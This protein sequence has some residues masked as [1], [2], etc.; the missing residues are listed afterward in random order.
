MVVQLDRQG[1]GRGTWKQDPAGLRQLQQRLLTQTSLAELAAFRRDWDPLTWAVE[2][3]QVRLPKSGPLTF[4]QHPFLVQVYRDIHP[5]IVALKGAQMGFSTWALIRFLW[6]VT[7]WPMSVIYTF[8]VQGQITEHTQSRIN[9]VIL[10]SSYL[11][12]RI[13]NVD[14]VM[15]KQFGLRG[16][17]EFPPQL[18]R[19]AAD[20]ARHMGE[21]GVSTVYFSGASRKDVAVAKDADMLIH[22]EEDRSDPDTIE[23]FSSRLSGPSP[24]KWKIRLSTPT[25]PGYGI[26][27]A[28]QATDRRRWML[29]CPHCGHRYVMRFPENIRPQTWAEHELEH[30]G[31]DRGVRCPDCHYVCD[32]CGG[33]VDD[34]RMSGE[35]VAERTTAGLA[36]GYQVGQMA[37]PYVPASE[38]LRARF[39]DYT[40]YEPDFWNVTMG[41]ASTTGEI[42][43]TEELFIGRQTELG[44]QP[45]LADPE[46][47]MVGSSV[48]TF[49]GVDV[50]SYLDYVVDKVER[51]GQVRTVAFGRL[52]SAEGGWEQLVDVIRAHRALTVVIDAFPEEEMTRRLC[53]SLNP[54]VG[55]PRVWRAMY[56]TSPGA[57]ELKWDEKLAVVQ[58][59]R[60]RFLS[61]T[62]S[63]LIAGGKILPRY[64]ST[65]T[66]R[67]YIDHHVNSKRQPV[68][69]EGHEDDREVDRWVW[70]ETGPDHLFHANLYAYVARKLPREIAPPSIGLISTDRS[71]AGQAQRQRRPAHILG[72]DAG[73]IQATTPP[74]PKKPTRWG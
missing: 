58:I 28:Y 34:A 69:R 50:G 8:P 60:D 71:K 70:R 14:N 42:A 17:S 13:V 66:W 49:I 74:G 22:D 72:A 1:P 52:P 61:E 19:T 11:S 39:V 31:V 36:H 44:W 15:Q 5:S 10:S 47:P 27:G 9:P 30:P 54:T 43:F 18:M 55:K 45:G 57:H 7:H 51:P 41:E 32:R 65:P 33:V 64:E 46:T 59:P 20:R 53:R 3:A 2:T 24:I 37:A 29:T 23:Q 6:A 48:G 62:A 40:R 25:I 21:A 16:R 12:D 63:E 67:A 38:I 4:E 35:W 73:P 56:L 68:F 26:D